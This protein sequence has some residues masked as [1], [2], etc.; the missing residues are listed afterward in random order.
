MNL[1]MS[2]FRPRGE[3]KLASPSKMGNL[4]SLKPP[5]VQ[6][7]SVPTSQNGNWAFSGYIMS[8]TYN[9]IRAWSSAEADNALKPEAPHTPRDPSRARA[10]SLYASR[11][12]HSPQKRT[13]KP[14]MSPAPVTNH[15]NIER[16][17][18]SL[19]L[20]SIHWISVVPVATLPARS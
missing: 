13:L 2:S 4:E 11:H 20:H 18:R 15:P 1:P 9:G 5:K 14:R 10:Y 16:N 12:P 7:S 19:S 6:I 3:G 17:N 8:C